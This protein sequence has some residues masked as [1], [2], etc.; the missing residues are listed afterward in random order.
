MFE[1]LRFDC[2][3][4]YEEME[5]IIPEN[6]HYRIHAMLKSSIVIRTFA[7]SVSRKWLNRCAHCLHLPRHSSSTLTL[8]TLWVVM[9]DSVA[10][11]AVPIC[12]HANHALVNEIL[13][14]M[15]LSSQFFLIIFLKDRLFKFLLQKKK[16]KKKKKRNKQIHKLSIYLRVLIIAFPSASV[17]PYAKWRL[18][19]FDGSWIWILIKNQPI[20][21]SL[22][23]S[24]EVTVDKYNYD[25]IINTWVYSAVNTVRIPVEEWLTL[26]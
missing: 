11:F 2:I 16:E 8:S 13:W 4:F 5:K 9:T 1:P 17:P 26:R 15:Y 7:I 20:M 25:L 23:F 12:H 3:C 10:I 14:E 21:S 6:M 18:W 22:I 24:N 19:P